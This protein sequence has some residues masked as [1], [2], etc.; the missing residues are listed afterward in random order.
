MFHNIT[1]LN[2][3]CNNI[4]LNKFNIFLKEMSVAK[5]NFAFNIQKVANKYIDHRRSDH[6]F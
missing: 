3:I 4:Y 2:I 1:K 6:D 5:V